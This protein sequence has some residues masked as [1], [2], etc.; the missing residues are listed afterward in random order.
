[1]ALASRGNLGLVITARSSRARRL[2]QGF[3]QNSPSSSLR[4]VNDEAISYRTE[5]KPEIAAVVPTY[6]SGLLREDVQD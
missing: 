1:V 4:G 6:L 2:D 3:L 5:Q